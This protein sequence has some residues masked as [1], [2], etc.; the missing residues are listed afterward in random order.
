MSLPNNQSRYKIYRKYTHM[1]Y[2][3]LGTGVR[4][5]VDECVQDLIMQEFP[6]ERGMRRT[7]FVVIGSDE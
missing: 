6:V 5:E 2:G 4:R 7:G 1:K 3:S